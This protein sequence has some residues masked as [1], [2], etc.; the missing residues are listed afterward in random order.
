MATPL[1]HFRRDKPP[2]NRRRPSS[3]RA[4]AIVPDFAEARLNLGNILME[5]G[6]QEA[7]IAAFRD[8]L[9]KAPAMPLVHNNLGSALARSPTSSRIVRIGRW[10]S[11]PTSSTAPTRFGSARATRTAAST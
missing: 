11:I 1:L 10:S 2:A 7:A 5:Q 4:L 3:R 6:R 8:V 9:A